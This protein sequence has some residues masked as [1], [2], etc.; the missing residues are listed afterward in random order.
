MKQK[1]RITEAQVVEVLVFCF[2]VGV[3]LAIIVGV[4]GCVLKG[5]RG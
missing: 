4:V 3:V 2:L 1:H 5:V